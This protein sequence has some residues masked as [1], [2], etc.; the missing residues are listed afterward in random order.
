MINGPAPAT[1]EHELRLIEL[2]GRLAEL[3]EINSALTARCAGMRGRLVLKDQELAGLR[4]ELNRR[5]AEDA[6][7]AKDEAPAAEPH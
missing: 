1:S 6:Q 4:E 7:R 3:S 5:A 2:S